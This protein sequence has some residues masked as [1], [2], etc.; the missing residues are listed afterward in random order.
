MK[1]FI[2]RLSMV[3]LSSMFMFSCTDDDKLPSVS[4]NNV[5]L[6]KNTAT[7][8]VTG[9]DLKSPRVNF[10]KKGG[11]MTMLNASDKGVF[12]VAPEYVPSLNEAAQ[13]TVY[14]AKSGTGIYAGNTYVIEVYD[15][16]EM[17]Y[18]TEYTAP[19][20]DAIPN[21]EM[22]GWSF[23][24]WIDTGQKEWPIT[25]PNAELQEGEKGFWDSGNNAFLEQYDEEG[26]AT[27][28]TPLCMQNVDEEGNGLGTAL[29]SA[30]MVLGFVFAPGNMFTGDFDYSGFSGT[31]KFGKA[32]RWTARPAGLRVT[33]KSKVG[34]IDKLGASDPDKADYAGK[35]DMST[36]YAAVIDWEHQHGVTSGLG[37]PTG[38]WDPACQSSVEEGSILGYASMDVT[39]SNQE[40]VTKDIMFNWYDTEAK[41]TDGNYSVV[42]SFA[43][44]KR[45]DY[46]T[47]CSTNTLEVDKMEWIY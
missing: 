11:P 3:A 26:N 15:G 33:F 20:G 10:G 44:S 38:M 47:G 23:R 36:I 34:V 37:T 9:A 24:T 21:A 18:I 25:Y 46:L 27:L 5:D 2:S 19:A 35:Q 12:E 28:M 30:R 39:E 17:V 45:G 7:V 13:S 14:T 1:S 29:L 32:Y 16:N 4:V 40:F 6:W 22:D 43:T 8:H 42:I 31:V 41:P